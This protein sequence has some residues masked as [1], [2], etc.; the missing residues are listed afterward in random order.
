VEPDRVNEVKVR[1][2]STAERDLALNLRGWELQARFEE[3]RPVLLDFQDYATL[4][5]LCNPNCTTSKGNIAF[6]KF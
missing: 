4:W 1:F 6:Y 3:V 5:A 2:V